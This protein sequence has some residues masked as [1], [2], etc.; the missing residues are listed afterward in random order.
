MGKWDGNCVNSVVI[1]RL[2]GM[3]YN[4]S[5]LRSLIFKYLVAYPYSLSY[6]FSFIVR[7]SELP[8]RQIHV[9]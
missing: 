6:A 1:L 9:M 4:L 2:L 7:N 8:G 3:D 5:V